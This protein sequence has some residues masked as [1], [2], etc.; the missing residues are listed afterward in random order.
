MGAF[1]PIGTSR[2]LFVASQLNEAEKEVASSLKTNLCSSVDCHEP[3]L[4]L[5]MAEQIRSSPAVPFVEVNLYPKGV[6]IMVR[7]I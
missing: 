5:S 1:I 2:K 3:R 4:I 6:D 7:K